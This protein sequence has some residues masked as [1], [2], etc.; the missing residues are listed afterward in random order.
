VTEHPTLN[1]PTCLAAHPQVSPRSLGPADWAQ[2][3]VTASSGTI[4][5]NVPAGACSQLRAAYPDASGGPVYP[6]EWALYQPQTVVLDVM[7]WMAQGACLLVCT[8]VR[9]QTYSFG[10]LVGRC[11]RQGL[12]EG[13]NC[14]T[15]CLAAGV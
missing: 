2:L 14:L 9:P 10:R 5:T 12:M 6:E 11:L 15:C 4:V 13:T 8:A 7:V 1:P 3:N